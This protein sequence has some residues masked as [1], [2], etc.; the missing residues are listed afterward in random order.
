MKKFFTLV[1]L[2]VSQIVSLAQF[3][4]TADFN[5]S[6]DFTQGVGSTGWLGAYGGNNPSSTFESSGG[7][8]TV[9]DTGGHW[10]NNLNSGHL[11]YLSL[12]GDFT[13]ECLLNSLS[14]STYA[15]AGIG[16]FDPSITSGSPTVTWIGAYYKGFDGEVGTRTE[17]NGS[18]SDY[19]P[20]NLPDSGSLSLYLEMTRVGDDFTQYY[21]LD[22]TDFT[23]I[24]RVT[25]SSLPET[26]DVGIWVGSYSGNTTTA[27][28]DSF[29]VSATPTPEPGT[30]ALAGAG[31]ACLL[32]FRRQK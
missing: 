21:S 3:S 29:S 7:Q 15:T 31:I 28:L 6:Q 14:S 16:A 13:M 22:G 17:V 10:E 8:L 30:I 20:Y 4:F 19:Y 25:M 9:S 5:Q 24:N 32:A 27:V 2:S 18:L 1:A 11:L 26:L 23:E 12:T